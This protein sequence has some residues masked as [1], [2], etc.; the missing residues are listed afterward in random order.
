MTVE[1]R[2][3]KQKKAILHLILILFK[4]RARIIHKKY[5]E[6]DTVRNLIIF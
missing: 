2:H 1:I 5:P 6:Y 3:D 4:L